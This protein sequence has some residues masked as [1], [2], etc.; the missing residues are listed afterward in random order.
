MRR[1]T[2]A[3]CAMACAVLSS[4]GAV[5]LVACDGGGAQP[6]PVRPPAPGPGQWS[7]RADIPTPRSEV[8]VAV[9]DGTVYVLGGFGGSDGRSRA[10]EAYD[11]ATDRWRA[12]AE[13]PLAL[14]HPGATA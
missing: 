9:L 11:P 7:A 3:V 6:S 8:G 4:V 12:R 10:N 1:I 2:P 14:D 5:G 13:L